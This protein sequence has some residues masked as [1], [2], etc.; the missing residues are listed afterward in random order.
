[1]TRGSSAKVDQ[2][3]GEVTHLPTK[4]KRHQRV[5]LPHLALLSSAPHEN[6]L[7]LERALYRLG[8]IH[9]RQEWAV[10]LRYRGGLTT[11]E[12]VSKAWLHGELADQAAAP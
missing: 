10:E 7:A 8:R 5:D 4:L 6:I 9:P 12:A 3:S 2:V 11:E 1:M